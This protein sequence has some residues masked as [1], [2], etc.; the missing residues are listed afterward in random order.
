MGAVGQKTADAL[1]DRGMQ[2]EL[3][4]HRTKQNAAGLAEAFPEYVEDARK[5]AA[6]DE[7]DALF[8]SAEGYIQLW[9]RTEARAAAHRGE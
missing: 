4:P 9:E 1:R 7:I 8:R 5:D 2:A 6:G 3:V